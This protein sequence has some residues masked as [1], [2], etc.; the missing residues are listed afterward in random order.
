MR[1]DFLKE[2]LEP[3]TKPEPEP[4]GDLPDLGE[5]YQAHA[6]AANKPVYTLHFALGRDGLRSFQ[7]VHLDSNSA[8]GV[9]G[10]LHVITLRFGGIRTVAVTIRGRNL[11]LL[12]DY[13]HQHRMP[14]VRRADRDFPDGTGKRPIVTAIDF[15]EVKERGGG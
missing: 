4:D 1:A 3:E 6:R 11:W 10:G 2:V 8:L 14:W 12:Y 5:P 15:E 13:I 9:E 7:Y